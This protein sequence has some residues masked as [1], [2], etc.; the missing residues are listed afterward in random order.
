M[1]IAAFCEEL[2]FP[3][4]KPI[5]IFT[6]SSAAIDTIADCGNYSNSKY[7][8]KDNNFIREKIQD[9]TVELVWISRVNNTADLVTNARDREVTEK[10]TF[11]LLGKHNC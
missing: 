2:K 11:Q 8:N 3:I 9:G 1:W 6:D 5:K 4:K 10:F 7:Y